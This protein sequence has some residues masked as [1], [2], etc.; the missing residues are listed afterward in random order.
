VRCMGVLESYSIDMHLVM[1]WCVKACLIASFH[2]L[3]T[4]H[5]SNPGVPV[6]VTLLSLPYQE[7]IQSWLHWNS[8]LNVIPRE[9]KEFQNSFTEFPRSFKHS[10]ITQS[11]YFTRPSFVGG[12]S[13]FDRILE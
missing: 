12:P 7:T 6:I 2:V 1:L 8:I 5:L 3:G 11:V 10:F 4:P 13:C 9:L